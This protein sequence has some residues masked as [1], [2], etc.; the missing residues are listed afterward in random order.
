MSSSDCCFLTCIQVSQEQVRYSHFFK[1]FPQ[2]VVIHTVK[3]FSVVIETEVDVF[4]EFSCFFYDLLDISNLISGSSAFS[5]SSLYI[6]KFS[7]H[8]LLK[9]SLNDFEHYFASMWNECSCV[10]VWT[11][12]GIETQENK[13]CQCFHFFSFYL[14]W[15]DETGCCDLRFLTVEF[16]ANFFALLF[17]PHQEAL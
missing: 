15:S 6:W 12:F 11:F 8:I 7:V 14:P 1:N 17:H 2:F 16:Q 4:L 5:K 10:V 9:P 13:I 3:S